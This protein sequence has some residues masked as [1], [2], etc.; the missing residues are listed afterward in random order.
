MKA[1][2][3]WREAASRQPQAS[4]QHGNVKGRAILQTSIMAIVAGIFFYRRHPVPGVILACLAGLVLIGGCF[5][6]SFFLAFEKAGRKFG[7]W[8]ATG[9]TWLLLVPF[10]YLC[11]V[12]GRIAILLTGKDP[13]NRQFPSKATTFWVPRPPVKD[14]SQ[15]GKQF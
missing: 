8:V 3:P 14:P 2:W 11:F 15:Y 1:I 6:P 10:Y 9:V 12:P 13:L 5:I 4:Q 7:Q